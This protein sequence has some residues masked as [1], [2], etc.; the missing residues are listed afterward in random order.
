[1]L[2][3]DNVLRNNVAEQRC[4][5]VL[6]GKVDFS[7]MAIRQVLSLGDPTLRKKSRPVVEF[8]RKLRQLLDDMN[9]TM[10]KEEGCGLAAPQVGVLRRVAVVDLGDELIEMVNPVIVATSDEREGAEG[11][12]SIRGKQGFVVRPQEVTFR[13]QDRHGDSYEMTVSG[14]KAVAVSHEIDHLDGVL[15]IDKMIRYVTAEEME[16]ARQQEAE[17]E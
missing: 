9:Q 13:A 5:T 11:C 10:H 8:S 2:L 16:E 1:M 15:Y 3:R 4:E 17:N 14:K 6:I 12:L 7:G